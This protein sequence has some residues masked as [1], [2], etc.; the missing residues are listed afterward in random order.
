[1]A[2]IKLTHTARVL[3]EVLPELIAA[4]KTRGVPIEASGA[5]A[6]AAGKLDAA[7]EWH[8]EDIAELRKT[9]DACRALTHWIFEHNQ[10][11]WIDLASD[12]EAM[13]QFWQLAREARYQVNRV[14]DDLTPA[15][16]VLG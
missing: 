5:V 12:D 13:E 6:R 7:I 9:L 4:Y 1:M 8:A 11:D 14:A 3:G 2:T 10:H 15:D 16:R